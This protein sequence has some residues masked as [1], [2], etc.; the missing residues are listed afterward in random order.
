MVRYGDQVSA[1][2]VTVRKDRYEDL[3]AVYG[4]CAGSFVLRLHRTPTR[5]PVDRSAE[6]STG[7]V[8]SSSADAQCTAS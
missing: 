7:L 8:V 4:G 6:R 1:R 5:L 2:S 3:L